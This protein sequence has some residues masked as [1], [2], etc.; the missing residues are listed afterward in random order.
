MSDFRPRSISEILDASFEIYRRHFAIFVAISVFATVPWSIS[1][2]M[3]QTALRMQQSGALGTTGVSVS[4]ILLG[5]CIAPFTEGALTAAA[6]A[7][8]LG[9]PVDF[10]QVIHVAFRN[11]GR[12]FIAMCTKWLVMGIGLI[13]FIV[14]GLIV[15]KRYFALPMTV[16]LEDNTVGD[17]ISRSRTLA[18]GNGGRIF[19][20]VG[21]VLVF[22]F[23][24]TIYLSGF[25]TSL[26][27]GALGAVARL[28][29]ATV[30]SPFGTIVSTVL[31]YDIRI[32]REG[33]D[34]ELMAQALNTAPSLEAIP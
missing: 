29:L 6:S 4:V 5:L 22:V 13:F 34:I 24:V 10:S 15:F 3:S 31:Y 14:P 18:V 2:Y 28:L 7:A 27:H 9:N 16:V 30:L 12:L 1:A 17:A 33:Y 8:Y 21:G 25:I 23:I 11:P 32:R 20:L 19:L 26:A